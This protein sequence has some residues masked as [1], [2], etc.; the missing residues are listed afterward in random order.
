M[1]REREERGER[2]EKIERTVRGER[3]MKYQNSNFESGCSDGGWFVI[4]R[5]YRGKRKT[6]PEEEGR[7][8]EDLASKDGVY[9]TKRSY[10]EVVK[11]NIH[12]NHVRHNTTK[13]EGCFWKQVWVYTSGEQGLSNQDD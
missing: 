13:K 10:A 8:F 11:H 12:P 3:S 5:D 4:G 9:G 2:R 1:E 7:D 6:L